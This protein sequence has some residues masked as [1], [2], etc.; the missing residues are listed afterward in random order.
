M[1]SAASNIVCPD[2]IMTAMSK[3]A[4][5]DQE[6]MSLKAEIERLT[7]ENEALKNPIPVELDDQP[8]FEEN[9]E[10]YVYDVR[11]REIAY[12]QYHINQM[13]NF[14]GY[15]QYEIA[16]RDQYIDNLHGQMDGC[17][18]H[19][20]Y[21]EY[22]LEESNNRVEDYHRDLVD[23]EQLNDHLVAVNEQLENELKTLKS[24]NQAFESEKQTF[25]SQMKTLKMAIAQRD[26]K[27]AEIR[28]QAS[29]S[30]SETLPVAQTKASQPEAQPKK[31]ADLVK[32]PQTSESENRVDGR[33]TPVQTL[34]VN[35][36][37]H[38]TSRSPTPSDEIIQKK[39]QTK[40]TK[41]DD[42]ECY[43]LL[44]LNLYDRKDSSS[45][46]EL[47]KLIGWKIRK[48]IADGYT[49]G[50][51]EVRGRNF[52]F[53]YGEV[54]RSIFMEENDI[55]MKDNVLDIYKYEKIGN[56]HVYQ[57]TENG[58]A[59]IQHTL[60]CCTCDVELAAKVD[61]FNQWIRDNYNE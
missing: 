51:E 16:N 30:V 28:R 55:F 23:C 40:T 43:L 37:E 53:K 59:V 29:V 54:T 35:Q 3:L 15:L 20:E 19:I 44:A 13:T 24:E 25:E 50:D 14:I 33:S 7:A 9:D 22:Q 18:A 49:Y 47:S 27:L 39:K 5:K 11:D 57:L 12:L 8:Q 17:D 52:L 56:R 46:T 58:Y 61:C 42:N 2:P 1:A 60:L 31:W 26:Q 34:V 4:E 36:Q 6:I 21:L 48:A 38:S 10:T 45:A 41:Y 32:Q